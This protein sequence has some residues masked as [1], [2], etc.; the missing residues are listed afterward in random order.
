MPL[1][2]TTGVH[3]YEVLRVF[4]FM[5]TKYNGDLHGEM[6][7]QCLMSRVSVVEILETDG[8]K[9]GQCKCVQCH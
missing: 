4:R 6:R 5:E 1:G 7:S 9:V 8:G 2:T 3:L